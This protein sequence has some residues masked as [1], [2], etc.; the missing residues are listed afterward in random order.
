MPSENA[1]RELH[2]LRTTIS[3]DD[4]GRNWR[5][6]RGWRGGGLAEISVYLGCGIATVLT[7]VPV[8]TMRV[9][10]HRVAA[11]H[12]LLWR[13]HTKTIESIRRESDG[14]CRRQNP[15]SWLQPEHAMSSVSLM[16]S[17]ANPTPFVSSL[18][19]EKESGGEACN[20]RSPLSTF[21]LPFPL[22][23]MLA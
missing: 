17:T 8:M 9:A 20:P 3:F 2:E 16:T 10:T 4:T 15:F 6:G 14:Q 11:L 5:K 23:T 1:R 19:L 22:D 7:K 12:R 13:S 18:L 21:R